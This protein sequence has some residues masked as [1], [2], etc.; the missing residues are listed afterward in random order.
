MRIHKGEQAGR[1]KERKEER[2]RH[3][4]PATVSGLFGVRVAKMDMNS[5]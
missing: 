3:G 1:R 4:I 5:W 2:N